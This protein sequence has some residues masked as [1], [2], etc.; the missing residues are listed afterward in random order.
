MAISWGAWEGSGNEMRV[1]I[2]VD[3][4]TITHSE[5]VATATVKIWTENNFTW[6]DDQS[7]NHGGSISGSTSFHNGQGDGVQT[8]RATKTYDY[9]YGASSYGSSP[10][11]RT[12]SSTLS[13]AFN[14]ITP[15]KSVTSNIPARPIAAPAAPTNAAVSRISDTSTKITWTNKDTAGEPWDNVILQK[16]TNGGAWVTVTS[17]IA[18][19]ATS[20][21]YASAANQKL[22]FRVASKNSEGTSAYDE[23]GD[24]YTTPSVPGAPT[25]TEQ[26]GPLQRITWSNSGVGYSEYSTEIHGY[27]NGAS[28]GVLGTVA[29]GVGTFDHTT[30]NPVSVYTTGD[31]WKYAVRHKTS[32]GTA[33]YSAYT[34]YTSET[35]GVTAPPLAP[36]N[37]SPNGLTLDPTLPQR[38]SWS[39][40]PGIVGDTQAA[41]TVQHRLAGAATWNE[42]TGTTNQFYDLPADTY[43]EQA[44][45]EWQVAT[46][47]SD[48]AYGPYSAPVS[49]LT[50]IT[51]IAPDPVKIPVV[52]DLFTGQLEASTTAHELKNFTQRFQ[53]QITGGGVRAVN[54]SY[55]LT[56]SQRFIAIALGRSDQT[57]PAGHHDIMNPYGWAHSLKEVTSN[58]AKLTFSASTNRARVGDEITVT[59]AGAP[60]D[61]AHIVRESGSNYVKFDVN[62][63]NIASTA[64]AGATFCT[65]HGHGGS[66][67]SYPNAG[68]VTL[69]GWDALWYEM[70]YGW[71]AGTTAKKNG[72]V[73]VTN[74]SLT[75]NVAT[76]TVV[77]PH[78]FAIGDRIQV[79]IG[80]A[81]FDSPAGGEVAITAMTGNTI[82]YAKTNANVASTAATGYAKPTGKDTFFGNFHRTTYSGDFVVP[83]NWILLALRN[84]D[85]ATV[86]WS[87]GD[88]V[89]PGFDSDSPVLKQVILNSTSDVTATAGNKPALR[90][91]NIAGFHLRMDANE[92]QA[93][94]DDNST[95]GF[96]INAGGGNVNIG[97]SS[98]IVELRGADSSVPNHITTTNGANV[99]M[100]TGGRW[101]RVTSSRKVKKNILDFDI[102]P[103][104][105][106][107]L[108]PKS[109]NS[110]LPNDDPNKRFVGFIAE[111]AEDLGLDSWVEYSE[112]DP[113]EV[114]GFYYT[115][116]VVALQHIA[117]HQRDKIG[118]LEARLAR[119]ERKVD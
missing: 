71:G 28:V 5:T 67:D 31:K 82:S 66:A 32:T 116:W 9:T 112:K 70:P 1:G 91:G 12:F 107:E 57:F 54:A 26:A 84:N 86:E 97:T 50:A 119:L 33:L 89:D 20:Y 73:S 106:L 109:Y 7:L 102:D 56:W 18:G 117:R 118:D 77:A 64:A 74:K 105:L 103:D 13:G 42:A 110:K 27:K 114:V 98:S 30:T 45:V 47:G 36:I 15:S 92:M 76:L 85:A 46:K 2:E 44:V 6:D 99:N 17:S 68:V 10:G 113:D 55:G 115:N 62:N 25:R 22:R 58:V 93:M 41:F 11:S 51:A 88:A 75:S 38:L 24:I 90:V 39:F 79:S 29:T 65:I 3:W 52:M 69:A 60:F 34:A 72:V 8:L 104:V 61:G 48:P 49:F 14:G 19:S 37:L 100:G 43:G 35:A 4:E 16:S 83:D 108:A 40:Q 111:E 94:S 78:Y 80:D 95:G 59:G 21:T 63:A 53:A 81:V 101:M 23:T 96:T 87:S